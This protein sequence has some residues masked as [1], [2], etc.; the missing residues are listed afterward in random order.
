[1]AGI[2]VLVILVYKF[3]SGEFENNGSLITGWW[4]IPGI[5]G[6]GYLVSALIYLAIRDN[7]LNTIVA[8][9]FFLTLNIFYKLD[10]FS[11]LHHITSIFGVVI[12]GKVPLIILSGVITTLILKKYSFSNSRKAILIIVTI[13]ISCILFGIIIRKWFNI[14]A[15]QAIPSWELICIG[16]SM[17][18]YALLHWT[19][20]IKKAPVRIHLIKV[21]GAYSLTTYLASNILYYLIWST[22]I[23]LFFYKQSGVYLI[24]IAG[25]IFWTLLMIAVTFLLVRY[26]IKLRL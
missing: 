14:I 4:G 12:E 23:P 25:S 20:D 18:L 3:R 19:I 15:I 13:G 5:I 16:I 7:I 11:A 1:M 9:L 26:N 22:H 24:V 10:Y 17:V 2:A 8:S 21:V 6:W